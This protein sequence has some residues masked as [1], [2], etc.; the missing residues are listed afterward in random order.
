MSTETKMK[1]TLGL[2]GLTMN[3]MALIAPGAFLWLTFAQQSLYGAP[4]AGQAM[5]FGI[6]AALVL[7]LATAISYAELSKL[8]PGAGSS[9]VFAEQA[10]INKHSAFKFARISKFI[11][12]WASHLYYWVYPGVMVAVTALL[13]G[14]LG[15]ILL[16]NTFSSA[17]PSPL[18]MMGFCVVFAYGVAFIAFRGV[19]SATAV[20]IAINVI[21]ITALVIFGALAIAYR[22]NHPEGS[23][24]YTLSPSGSVID[25]VVATDK[26]GK[27]VTD[28][29]G[30]A[31]AAKDAAGNPQPFIVSYKD[32]IVPVAD[33]A[34]PKKMNDTFQMHSSAL[35]V[36]K[37]HGFGFVFV[38]MGIAIL[39][40]VGFESVSAMG[41]ES[42]NPKSHIPKAIILSLLI[43]GAVC[44]LF[45]YFAANFFLHSGY[46]MPTA[47]G[48]AAPI[49]DMMQIIG[50][51]AFGSPAAG[52]A[53]MLVEAGTVFLALVGTTLSCISTGA[54]VT[55]AMGR[56]EELGTHF[57]ILHGTNLTPARAIW[58]LATISAVIGIFGVLFNFCGGAAQ[59]D[60]AIKA[61]PTNI[62]YSFGLWKN[63]LAAQIPQSLLVITLTSNFGTF[64]LYMLTNVIAIVAFKEHHTFHGF[65]H[66]V[67]P[68][69]GLLANFICLLFYVVGPFFVA[70]MSWKE[71]YVALGF[72]LVWGLYGAYYFATRSK[73]LGREVLLT[74]KPASS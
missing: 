69:F 51:W 14:Y 36:I 41:E 24:G 5:W 8:Y 1:P 50:T 31:V 30:N 63:A 16:P 12:G 49:G 65:K 38:Q 9:Y 25:Y 35:S 2:T 29:D 57:G 61:L 70:G 73:K 56:D 39:L 45:E 47:G 34:D 3:A 42:I 60:D 43:Q 26:D 58:T 68:V 46:T 7:C 19:G 71:P 55:Y 18:F 17:I 20:N 32:S 4:L 62:W 64:A 48:S 15:G 44:Y 74:Q 37:P 27:P 72:A 66:V 13:A 33:A 28:K 6:V 22:A 40:L 67:V 21:Q 10:F 52:Q 11:V 59:T 53:F 54:R 23:K